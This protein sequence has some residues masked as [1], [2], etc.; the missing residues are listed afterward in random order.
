[1]TEQFFTSTI[2]SNITDIDE[3]KKEEDNCTAFDHSGDQGKEKT[4]PSKMRDGGDTEE[5][6]LEQSVTSQRS[7]Y[8]DMTERTICLNAELAYLGSA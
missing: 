2:P 4:V 6:C 8:K 7:L 3:S 1:M 5:Y